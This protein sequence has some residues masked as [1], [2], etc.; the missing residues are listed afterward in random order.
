MRAL[1]L[2]CTLKPCPAVSNT[3]GLARVVSRRLEAEG[4]ETEEIRLVDLDSEI[5]GALVD[6][7][8][9]VPGQAWTYWNKGP[10]PGPSYLEDE[11]GHDWSE[12]TGETAALNLL[13]VAR[14]LAAQPMQAP[15]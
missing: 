7:G 4:V 10:G 9:T 14:A 3:E 12:T 11:A 6:I 15:S 2:N 1:V 5:A 8:F 13:T